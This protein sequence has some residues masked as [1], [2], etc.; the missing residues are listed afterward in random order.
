MDQIGRLNAAQQAGRLEQPK[1]IKPTSDGINV[2]F[3]TNTVKSN[4][5]FYPGLSLNNKA[6]EYTGP[7]S[8]VN[9]LDYIANL[10]G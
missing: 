9:Y 2:S 4:E 8:M 1:G 6:P 10:L 5:G 3:K 7:E